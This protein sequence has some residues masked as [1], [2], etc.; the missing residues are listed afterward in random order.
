MSSAAPYGL[1]RDA[2]LSE[3]RALVGPSLEDGLRRLSSF[4]RPRRMLADVA[5]RIAL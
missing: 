2:A 4:C 3:L 5:E 1:T